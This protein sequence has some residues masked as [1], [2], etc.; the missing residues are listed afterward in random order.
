MVPLK[1]ICRRTGDGESGRTVNPL[2]SGLVGSNPTAGTR[3]YSGVPE[4]VAGGGLLIRCRKAAVGSS[5]TSRAMMPVSQAVRQG[6]LKPLF[7]GS[8]PSPATKRDYDVMVAYDLAM[9]EVRVRFSIVA[10]FS[11]WGNW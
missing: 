5:P 3:H 1:H 6:P 9:V 11:M 8:N 2:P 7:G 4:L 10:Y